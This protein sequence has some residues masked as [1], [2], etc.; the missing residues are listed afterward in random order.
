MV[1][2]NSVQR[3]HVFFTL[4]I[5]MLRYCTI[6]YCYFKNNFETVANYFALIVYLIF[7]LFACLIVYGILA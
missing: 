4:F 3:N 6:I 7:L 2:N 1:K 5:V